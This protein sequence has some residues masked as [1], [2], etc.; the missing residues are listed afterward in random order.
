VDKVRKKRGWMFWWCFSGTSK[1]PCLFCEKKW[2]SINKESYCERIIPLVD[3]WLGLNPY[4]QFMQDGAPGHSAAF[5]IDE[6]RDRVITPIFWPAFSP[7]LNPIEVVWKK[8]K[9]WI[10]LH[11]PDLPAGKQRTYDQLRESVREA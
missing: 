7:D 6:L 3:G 8:M 5:T 4:L 2:K 1:G 10:E 11:Y 9:D